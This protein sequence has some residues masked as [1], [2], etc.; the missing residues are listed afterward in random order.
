MVLAEF[1][2]ALFALIV[3]FLSFEFHVSVGMIILGAGAAWVIVAFVA[4]TVY[5]VLK[6][7]FMG[8]REGWRK[9]KV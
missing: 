1:I 4:W 9:G 7:V 3:A 2:T 6:S 5:R 8:A